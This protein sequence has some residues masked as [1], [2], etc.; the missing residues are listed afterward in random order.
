MVLA[1]RHIPAQVAGSARADDHPQGHR[2][3][4]CTQVGMAHCFCLDPHRGHVHR[5]QSPT[6]SNRLR[7]TEWNPSGNPAP[8]LHHHSF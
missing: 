3:I 6:K 5:I 8:H 1:F 2:E 4:R 7:R